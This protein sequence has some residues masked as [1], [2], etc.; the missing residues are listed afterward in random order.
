MQ[1]VMIRVPGEITR[2]AKV[3]EVDI[4][5]TERVRYVYLCMVYY[6]ERIKVCDRL[7]ERETKENVSI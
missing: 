7:S 5:K 4:L 6:I 3:V 2:I 1:P